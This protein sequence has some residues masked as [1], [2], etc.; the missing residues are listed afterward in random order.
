MQNL[1]AIRWIILLIIPLVA[2]C[3]WS[4]ESGKLPPPVTEKFLERTSPENLLH[5]FGLAWERKN[6]EEY[7]LLFS[8]DYTFF[9]SDVDVEEHPDIPPSWGLEQDKEATR[10]LF[11]DTNVED[12]ELDWVVG[13]REESEFAQADVKILVTNIYL[14]V[15]IRDPEDGVLTTNII[16]GAADFHFR[17]TEET[18]AEGDTLWHIVVWKDLTTVGP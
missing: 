11:E 5:N 4:T 7:I 15:N 2:G 6:F 13:P 10:G 8:E 3:P 18:T 14:T 16:Q 1:K 12:V 9:F 17:K